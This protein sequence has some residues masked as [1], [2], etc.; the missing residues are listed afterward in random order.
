MLTYNLDIEERS[1]WLRTTPNTVALAQPY[2][3]TEAGLFYGRQRF[4]TARS[5]KD[6]YL[7][8]YTLSGAGLV[9]QGP[10]RIELGPRQALLLN[11]RT[12]Q[13]YCTA[14]RAGQ[15]HHYWVHFDGPGVQAMEPLLIPAGRL[16][17]VELPPEKALDA[18]RGI[19]AQLPQ[20]TTGSVVET[21]LQIHQLLAGM[22]TAQCAGRQL[23]A[24]SNQML[25]QRM[26]EYLREH[27]SEDLSLDELV[28][29]LPIS[30]TY[31]LRLFQR[32]MGTTPYNFLL[33]HRI[34]Q[35]KELLVLTDLPVGEVSRRVGFN[36]ESNFS[37][38]F[39][40]MTW[41]SPSQYRKSALKQ[42]TAEL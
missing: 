5:N 3:C 35:A 1:V 29:M 21:G 20:E 34:T 31:F 8:F 40:A 4:A 19:L 30:K 12:P 26:V 37:T 27:Y 9:E 22:L 36:S 25:V 41:Q 16:Q 42:T 11:C 7:F 38:R 23:T 28:A 15:W 6:S 14:P 18:L 39:A 13:S 24:S 32:V 17:P 33:C 2:Y 10:S